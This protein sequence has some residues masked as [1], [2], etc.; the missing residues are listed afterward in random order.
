V[1]PDGQAIQTQTDQRGRFAIPD[2]PAGP[3]HAVAQAP[4]WSPAEVDV[5]IQAG[6]ALTHV[7][8]LERPVAATAE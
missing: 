6:E 1:N 7:F 3:Y 8:I 4:N 5:Q 2:V